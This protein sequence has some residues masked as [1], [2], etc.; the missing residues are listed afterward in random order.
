[1]IIWELYHGIVPFDGNLNAAVQ[2]VVAENVRPKILEANQEEEAEDKSI[3]IR[4][5]CSAP[6]ADLIRKCWDSNPASR[7]D[8]NAI[9]RVLLHETTFFSKCD[10]E[11]DV[12]VDSFEVIVEE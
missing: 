9:L 4:D 5:P 1:M 12:S 11:F 10:T 7:P 8:F 6:I 3:I 2:C